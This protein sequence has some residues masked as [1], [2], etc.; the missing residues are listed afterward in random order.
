[1][2]LTFITP[3]SDD[4]ETGT[5]ALAKTRMKM[6]TINLHN[7]KLMLLPTIKAVEVPSITKQSHFDSHQLNNETRGQ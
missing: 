3:L 2:P 7:A 5:S 4:N 1:M 6:V